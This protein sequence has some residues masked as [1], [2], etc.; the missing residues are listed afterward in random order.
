M[1]IDPK[2]QLDMIYETNINK[3]SST[4]GN[5]MNKESEL[6]KDRVEISK[7]ASNYD[8]LSSIKSKVVEDVEKGTSVDKIRKLKTEID[9]GTYFVGSQDI[10]SAIINSSKE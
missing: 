9:N 2:K 6:N 10:A 8:E 3:N 5:K 1:R 4:S 7:A